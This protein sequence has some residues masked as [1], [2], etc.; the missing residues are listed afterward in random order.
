MEKVKVGQIG[1]GYWGPNLLRNLVGN[2]KCKVESV[3]D[4]SADRR[5]FIKSLYPDL[6]VGTDVSEIFGDNSIKAVLIATPASTHFSLVMKALQAGKHV[7]VEKPMA[8]TVN[9]VAAI[10]KLAEQKGLVAMVGHTFLYHQSV[11]FIKNLIIY[12]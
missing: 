9:E 11:R 3:I 5:Q 6:N 1:V 8:T 7:L 12:Y 4:L 2:Q 10:D